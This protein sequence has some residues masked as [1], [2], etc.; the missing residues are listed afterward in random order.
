MPGRGLFTESRD[1]AE[2]RDRDRVIKGR[3]R[4]TD[5]PYVSPH[6]HRLV[7]NLLADIVHTYSAFV[8]RVRYIRI[9]IAE[10]KKSV[11]RYSS[12]SQKDRD[13]CSKASFSNGKF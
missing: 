9:A 10:S 6:A 5:A 13:V 1:I 12:F 4:C 3:A 8:K 2:N 11:T 7:I